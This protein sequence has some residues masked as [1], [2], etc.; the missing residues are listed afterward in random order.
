MSFIQPTVERSPSGNLRCIRCKSIV[1]PHAQFCGTC[2]ERV[3]ESGGLAPA[4]GR[5]AKK[6]YEITSLVRRRSYVQ[7]FFAIDTEHQRAVGIRDIDISSLDD[8][9]R[10]H[11]TDVLQQEY[12]LLRRQR[13]HDVM[14][15]IDVHADEGH[16]ATVAGWPFAIRTTESGESQELT[17]LQTLSDLLQSGVD[18]PDERL[19]LAWTYRLCRA[20][21]QLHSHQILI[22]DLDPQAIVVSENSY[23]GLP[24]L[25]VSWLPLS[26]RTLLLPS[27]STI[28]N[29]LPFN[30]P[31]TLEGNIE[32][33]SD[34]YSLG[35]LL[36]LLL[37]GQ[38]PDDSTQ[39]TRHPLRS[40]QECNSGLSR[41]ID[42]VVMRAL[43]LESTNRFQSAAE[44]ADALMQVYVSAR[45]AQ[46][47]LRVFPG[48]AETPSAEAAGG[49]VDPAAQPTDDPD[50]VTISIVPLQAHLA[51]MRQ[52][53]QVA[54]REAAAQ[55]PPRSTE[56]EAQSPEGEAAGFSPESLTSDHAETSSP[57]RL[58]GLPAVFPRLRGTVQKERATQARPSLVKQVLLN[59]FERFKRFL[60]A[61]QQH[62]TTAAAV[63]ETPLRVQ[64]NQGYTIRI[65]LTGRDAPMPPQSAE[66]GTLPI[67]LSA[68][69]TGEIVHIEVRSALF[70]T[71]AYI[72]QRADVNLP[73]TGY[74]AEV[75]I[76][77]QPLSNGPTGRYERLHIFFMDALSRPL[78]EKPF[79]VEVLI[80]HLVPPGREGYNVLTIPF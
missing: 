53:Q 49:T 58:G 4:Q 63:I 44:M 19:A 12:D 13:I 47:Q 48:E 59:W 1:P 14:P 28:T 8:A 25:M 43:A 73:G 69:V 7:L 78:Y 16:I 68:L 60:L 3:K 34:I 23:S 62:S 76:P 32:P 70:Q 24:A 38:A 75:T 71:Y 2:G 45:S 20:I 41:G 35:A 18:L 39:R 54:S 31:E 46:G 79:V 65:Q 37:T 22:G 51:Q 26:V 10:S 29:P 72:V 17:R 36:Y 52:V 55:H 42:E 80:S 33:R 11:A 61:E 9:K 77:M 27:P 57:Q 21:A 5:T 30:A 66:S 56:K 15:V 50:D 74:A 6:R 67:G 64:P 40:P